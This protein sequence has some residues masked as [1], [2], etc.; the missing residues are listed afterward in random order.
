MLKEISRIDLS[1]AGENCRMW[2]GDI[3]GDGALEVVMVQPD[4]GIDDRYVPHSVVA[5]TA[6]DVSGKLLW[7]IGR[8][9]ANSSPSGSDIPAQIYDINGDGKNEFICVKNQKLCIFEGA[10]GKLLE[11]HA[12]PDEHAHDCIIIADFDG[13]GH[14]SIV[15]KNRYDKLWILNRDYSVRAMFHGNI[16]HFPWPFDVNGD[17][18]EELIAGY[19]V[20]DASGN[21]LWSIDMNDHADCISIGDINDDKKAEIIFGGADTRA[22]D[23]TGNLLW[24]YDGT[25]ESQ[26]AA[27]GRVREGRTMQIC[28]LDRINRGNPGLD[29]VFILSE[30][31]ECLYKEKRTV[32]GWS[33]IVGTIQNID[34]S[35]L[36]R[37]LAYRRGGL[38][39]GVYD[40]QMQLLFEFP[41]D[42]YVAWGDIVNSGLNQ[43]ILYTNREARI[44]SYR[45]V[46][47]TKRAAPIVQSKRLYNTTRYLGMEVV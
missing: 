14:G 31:G 16:G 21:V 10:S 40:G 33:S 11:E 30:T 38:C 35:K 43:L 45:D 13:N 24:A 46:D 3:N 28:G 32:P 34:D 22:Y 5:A 12:L 47:L 25:V 26:N 1:A 36:D 7:Q 29:G 4:S 18:R 6:F 2:L 20:I 23:C 9:D 15:L 8:P 19:N 42:G 39:G 27:I 41:F 44:F 17:G 37:I